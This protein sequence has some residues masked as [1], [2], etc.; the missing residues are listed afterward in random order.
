MR[1][2]IGAFVAA[3]IGLSAQRAE[4]CSCMP[5]S[6]EFFDTVAKH[7]QSDFSP[8]TIVTGKVLSYYGTTPAGAPAGMEFEVSYL[9]EGNLTRKVIKV[10]GDN[11]ML[12]RPYITNFPL[13]T[14][15]ALAVNSLDG[16][17]ENFYISVC[18]KYSRSINEPPANP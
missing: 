7:K 9:L 4:A 8:L 16:G 12:C 5:L 18:G 17:G 13:G 6:F 3:V 11:G 15:W 10:E 1:I 14:T 2:L